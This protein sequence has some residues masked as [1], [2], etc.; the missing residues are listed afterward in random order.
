[1]CCRNDQVAYGK[2]GAEW[3]FEQLNGKGNVVEMRGIDGV[4]ADA[5]RH[6]GFTEALKD[7]PDIKVVAT[8]F[9][10]WALNKAAQQT[11]DLLASGKQIDGIWTS[12]LDSVGGRRLSRPPASPSCRWSA[13]TTTA[14]S[15]S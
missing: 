5:D 8:P 4:P 9:T 1:M 12:G 6:Q 15:A 10:G 2:L 13:P 3:L 7:Y 14:S 11:K